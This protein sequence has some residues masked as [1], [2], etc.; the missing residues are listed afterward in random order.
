MAKLLR[1]FEEFLG[2]DTFK[3]FDDFDHYV[4]ADLWTTQATDS[5]TVSV[6]DA[7]AGVVVIDPSDSTQGD[8]DQTYMHQ[9]VETFKFATDKPMLFAARV[10]PYSNTIGS[11]NFMVGLK[12]APTT[13]QLADSGAVPTITGS[14]A[15]FYK[16][17]GG[18]Y[19]V[20]TSTANGTESI[21]NG[22]TT[23]HTVG[24]NAWDILVIQTI[25][26]NSTET[27]VHF[28][29]ADYQ[30]DGS[31]SLSEVGLQTSGKQFVAQKVTHTSATEMEVTFGVKEGAVNL[32]TELHVD[33]VYCAQKR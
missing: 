31:Y 6:S 21:T 1:D 3:I 12:N 20:C 4:T 7:V 25:P 8:N 10:R 23:E 26:I 27:E 33:W 29:S 2:N 13:D 24:N 14:G 9:T 18:T 15:F 16:L 5:G 22:V 32:S 11:A 19:W 28:F 17:D 30:T